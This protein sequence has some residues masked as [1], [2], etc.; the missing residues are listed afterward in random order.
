MGSVGE[1]ITLM[2]ERRDPGWVVS[3]ILQTMT[4]GSIVHHLAVSDSLFLVNLPKDNATQF[5]G[6]EAIAACSADH[7]LPRE[8]TCRNDGLAE[9]AAN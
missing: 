9:L 2:E 3:L 4:V 1:G 5:R 7:L 6:A 8:I